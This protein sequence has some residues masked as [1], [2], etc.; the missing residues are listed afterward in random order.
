M[1][2]ARAMAA[3]VDGAMHEADDPEAPARGAPDV[4]GFAEAWRTL[5]SDAARRHAHA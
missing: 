2:G 3:A 5:R 1:A 4:A